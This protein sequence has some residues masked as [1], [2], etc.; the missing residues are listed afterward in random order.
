M[1]KTAPLV[2]VVGFLGAG[3]TTFLRDLL[4][5]LEARGLEPYV[6]INDYANA[7]VDASSLQK[8]GR[9]VSPISGNCICCDS[10]AELFNVLL[11]I[12][13][14]EN[15][16]VLVE[17]N[18]TTDPAPLIE[19]LL[20]NSILRERFDPLIQ[21]TIVD[22]KRWQRRHWHNELERMQVEHASH[23]QFTRE[24]EVSKE[25][26][27]EV[28]S[29]IDWFNP[30]AQWVKS[31]RFAVQLVEIARQASSY[32]GPEEKPE[33]VQQECHENHH[34]HEHTHDGNPGNHELS[35]AFIGIELELPDPMPAEHLQIWLNS[36]P[37][38][39]LRVKGVVRLSEE[40]ECWYQFQRVEKFGG[41]ASLY[42]LSQQPI[43]PA[44]AVLIG[45]HLD[46]QA[47]RES[48]VKLTPGV[49]TDAA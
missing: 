7:R 29:D 47:I 2:I 18:G 19:H 39:V 11:E 33:K 17:A 30:K 28:R 35:H 6:L 45:V 15:R 48:L 23:I 1:T 4:P 25:R 40:P 20:V 42:Q 46:E 9:V 21:V 8:D 16:I 27:A 13:L 10:L 34:D 24:E 3:K 38:D 49:T 32:K 43:V 26:Y 36:L 14:S 37:S 5:Q 12:P 41:D 44:C 22:L 31:D